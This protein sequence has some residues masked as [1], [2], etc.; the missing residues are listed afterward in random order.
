M[1]NDIVF[2]FF[3]RCYLAELI[4]LDFSFSQEIIVT[5]DT[6]GIQSVHCITARVLLTLFTLDLS[7]HDYSYWSVWQCT[8]DNRYR[9]ADIF[10]YTTHMYVMYVCVC[11][12]VLLI[13]YTLS[14]HHRIIVQFSTM[15]NKSQTFFSR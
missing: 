12:C 1:F 13:S 2:N 3:T 14:K 6:H 8:I 7:S 11:V 15:G 5:P 10:S 9:W 4:K